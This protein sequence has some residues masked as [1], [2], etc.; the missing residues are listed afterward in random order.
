MFSSPSSQNAMDFEYTSWP[1]LTSW[2]EPSPRVEPAPGSATSY[3]QTTHPQLEDELSHSTLFPSAMVPMAPS[4]EKPTCHGGGYDANVASD[5]SCVES[6]PTAVI[7]GPTTTSI[8]SNAACKY[9]LDIDLSP[10]SVNDNWNFSDANTD[11]GQALPLC[12]SEPLS[13]GQ[14]CVMALYRD[15]PYQTS[16]MY[17]VLAIPRLRGQIVNMIKQVTIGTSPVWKWRSS[18]YQVEMFGSE[19]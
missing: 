5:A 17:V 11:P 16:H 4:S 15:N 10:S 8:L 9:L 14:E 6:A 2:T 19:E 7:N 3:D 1:E 18:H 13:T 12:I